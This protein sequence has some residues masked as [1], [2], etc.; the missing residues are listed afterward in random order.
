MFEFFKKTVDPKGFLKQED[1]RGYTVERTKPSKAIVPRPRVRVKRTT[2]KQRVVDYLIARNGKETQH[3][4]MAK[5]MKFS[6]PYIT[7]ILNELMRSGTIK[8]TGKRGHYRYEVVRKRVNSKRVTNTAV[9]KVKTSKPLQTKMPEVQK[10]EYG[11]ATARVLAFI[12]KHE[13]EAMSQNE[14]ARGSGTARSRIWKIVQEL[15]KDKAIVRSLPTRD[16]TRYWLTSSIETGIELAEPS[17]G[18]AKA[19][20]TQESLYEVIDH[21]VWEFMKECKQTDILIFLEWLKKSK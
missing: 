20:S 17:K 11:T 10:R 8:R 13:D 21:L 16:G 5:A 18:E 2:T 9:K 15:E 7:T 4:K 14:L 6:E 19:N 12:A 3:I 1:L